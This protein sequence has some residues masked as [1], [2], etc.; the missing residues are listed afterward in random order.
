MALAVRGWG[1]EVVLGSRDSSSS[2]ELGDALDGEGLGI[3]LLGLVGIVVWRIA[4]AATPAGH[5]AAGP[6]HPPLV[7]PGAG[8]LRG[9]QPPGPDPTGRG[10][11]ARSRPAS[12]CGSACRPGFSA[13]FDRAGGRDRWPPPSAPG[14]SG[15]SATPPTP[16]SPTSRSS[17]ATPCRSP[18]PAVARCPERRCGSRSRSGSTRTGTRSRSGCPSATCCS[19]GEPGAG[20]SAALS[21]FI[22]AAALDPAVHL[23][24]LDG[25]QVEL[26]PW[27]GSAEHFVGPDMAG[28]IE[29]LKDLCAEMDRRYSVLLAVGPAQDRARRR[30]RAPRR[31]HRRARL[32]HARRQ[33]RTSGPS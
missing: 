26:A 10:H 5:D 16:R 21:L 8:R 15:W 1:L 12:G 30:V 20:K 11:R 25:K 14:R 6:G 2:G 27:S 24:L 29:V 23:T 31:R 17:G 19:G 3:L 33:P 32:L 13:E 7:Q 9:H 18:A 4:R 28:A 22:A